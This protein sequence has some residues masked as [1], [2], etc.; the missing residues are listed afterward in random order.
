MIQRMH[1]AVNC[2]NLKK[3]LEFYKNFFGQ[4]PAKVRENYA[5]FEID[6]PGL[7][8][9]LNVRP[10]EK[11][12]VLNHLGFQVNNTEDVLAMGGRLRSAGLLLIDKMDTTCCYAVQDKVWVHDPDGNAWEIFYTKEDSEFES[13][14]DARDL[15]LCCAPPQ[16]PQTIQLGFT[17]K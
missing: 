1:V 16:K 12:G 6:E 4:E 7:H 10:F 15:S 14:G 3:S 17:K 2:T 5:K 13:A 8:F 11:E 9:S